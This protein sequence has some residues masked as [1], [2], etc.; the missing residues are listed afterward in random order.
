MTSSA[1]TARHRLVP[2][3]GDRPRRAALQ[4]GC[5]RQHESRQAE[6]RMAADREASLVTV[7][8]ANGTRTSAGTGPGVLRLSPGAGGRLPV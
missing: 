8:V 5:Q 2:R 4:V 6:R 1:V 3:Q 7:W